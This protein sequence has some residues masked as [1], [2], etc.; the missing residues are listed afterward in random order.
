MLSTGVFLL[1]RRHVCCLHFC[2]RDAMSRRHVDVM[3]SR[4]HGETPCF[5]LACFKNALI[6]VSSISFGFVDKAF[7]CLYKFLRKTALQNRQNISC[8]KK[9]QLV[10]RLFIFPKVKRN[11]NMP[12]NRQEKLGKAQYFTMHAEIQIINFVPSVN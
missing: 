2:C 12:R 10:L 3:L 8:I 4:H 1:S 9:K 6:W 11:L 7:G 5:Q